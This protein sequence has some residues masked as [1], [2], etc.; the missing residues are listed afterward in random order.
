LNSLLKGTVDSIRPSGMPRSIFED[1]WQ[2]EDARPIQRL[3][4]EAAT[5]R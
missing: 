2:R 5:E 4:A 1:A 3:E